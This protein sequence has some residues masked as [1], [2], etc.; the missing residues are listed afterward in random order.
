MEPGQIQTYNTILTQLY[1]EHRSYREKEFQ[2]FLFA[3]PILGSGLVNIVTSK[4]LII[5]LSLFGLVICNYLIRN[6]NR[7]MRIRKVIVGIQQ[8]LQLNDT[9]LKPLNPADWS[10]RPFFRH[11]GT[12]TYLALILTEMAV[13]LF[14][15]Y[16]Q[17]Q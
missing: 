2:T 13:L 6:I 16:P 4:P 8:E 9:I 7:L 10:S 17:L 14:F 12:I 3:F 11:L 1:L 15:K 5:M